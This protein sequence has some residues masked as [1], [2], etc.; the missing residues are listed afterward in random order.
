VSRYLLYALG[1][2][3][4]VV[5]GILIALQVN[6]LNEQQKDR[7][8]LKIAIH[9]LQKEIIQ[10]SISISEQLPSY[11]DTHQLN[12]SLMDRAYSSTATLDTLI[13]IMKEEFP[14]YW[15]SSLPFNQNTFDNLKSAGTFELVPDQIKLALSDY[16]TTI[17]WNKG[18]TDLYTD[19]YRTHLDDFVSRYSMVGRIHHPNYKNS[20]LF[21]ASWEHI[22]AADFTPRVTV[23][24]GAYDVMYK[25]EIARLEALQEKIRAILPLLTPYLDD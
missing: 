16:Y 12:R 10:D 1:E 14:V 22:D 3:V 19:Q 13:Q 11:R 23:V 9:S 25:S 24:L 15:I 8:K 17:L 2:I 7:T 5:I 20:F 6:N 4:L 21:N 18:I